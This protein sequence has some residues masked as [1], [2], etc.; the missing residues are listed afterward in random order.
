MRA[1]IVFVP[2]IV[3]SVLVASLTT[4][5]PAQAAGPL[6]DIKFTARCL[7]GQ[8]GYSVATIKATNTVAEPVTTD[9]VVELS[10]FAHEVVIKPGT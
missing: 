7:D 3:T 4:A 8:S 1:R 2:P 10:D 5:L 6:K 9:L